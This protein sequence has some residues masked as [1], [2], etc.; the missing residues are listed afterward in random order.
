M[1]NI[2]YQA[3]LLSAL[4]LVI[5]TGGTSAQAQDPRTEVAN[6]VGIQQP[7]V[8]NPTPCP[9]KSQPVLRP[10]DFLVVNRTSVAL[11]C[12]MK[13][14]GFGGWSE[15]TAVPAG[16]RLI[17]RK[18]DFDEIHVQCKAP[19]RIAPVRI[20]PGQRYA[21]LRKPPAAEVTLVKV[22]P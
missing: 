12:R 13:N 21:L 17:D 22:V 5:T 1:A 19:A 20:H 18:L 10:N 14:P 6:T 4:L 7:I 9:L 8:L 15:F 3:K 16:A 2:Q 11:Q